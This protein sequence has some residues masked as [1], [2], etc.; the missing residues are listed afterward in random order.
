MNALA[1]YLADV[2]A[3]L[4]ELR[5]F[6]DLTIRAFE[7]PREIDMSSASLTMEQRAWLREQFA[8]YEERVLEPRR[9]AKHEPGRE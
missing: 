3:E 8:S 1:E 9:K 5:Q 4:D 6:K 2:F 7:Y